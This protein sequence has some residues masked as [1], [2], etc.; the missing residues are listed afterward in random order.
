M[1]CAAEVALAR[2]ASQE[3]HS[4]KAD[5]RN[6]RPR[7]DGRAGAT[8]A[9]LLRDV[10]T[11]MRERCPQ[12]PPRGLWRL[13][14]IFAVA[15]F[16]VGCAAQNVRTPEQRATDA[17]L[18]LQVERAL[19]QDPNI[20]ARHIDVDADGGIVRLSGFVWAAD[21]YYEAQR[22][23][24][25]VPGVVRVVDQLEMVVGGRTGAR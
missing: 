21:D 19:A 2:R 17:A 3:R 24:A 12:A 5:A 14:A 13:A 6:P 8:S 16:A 20:Y 11:A 15:A 4:G 9:A 1:N 10:E 25:K 23:A 22:V 7:G 18:A